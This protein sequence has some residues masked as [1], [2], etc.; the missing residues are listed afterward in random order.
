MV[1]K[2]H[3]PASIIEA[4]SDQEYFA[5]LL[6]VEA[7][8]PDL[9]EQFEPDYPDLDDL[10]QALQQERAARHADLVEPQSWYR[11]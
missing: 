1:V 7:G 5:D 6:T 9:L 4:I 2:I 3:R 11:S 8:G 10:T